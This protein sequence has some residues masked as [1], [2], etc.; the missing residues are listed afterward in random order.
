M[1]PTQLHEKQSLT[2]YRRV[3]KFQAPIFKHKAPRSYYKTFLKYFDVKKLYLL[4]V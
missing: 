2:K 3:L 1:R 4:F